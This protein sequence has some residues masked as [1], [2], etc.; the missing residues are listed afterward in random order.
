MSSDI[1]AEYRRSV[2][3]RR[4]QPTGPAAEAQRDTLLDRLEKQENI[5][6]ETEAAFDR[7][8]KKHKRSYTGRAKQSGPGLRDS[9]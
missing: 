5:E 8:G 1:F 7:P 4:Q 3:S 6:P 9:R 2:L